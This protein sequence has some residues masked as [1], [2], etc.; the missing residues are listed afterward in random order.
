MYS[1]DRKSYVN[2][3]NVSEHPED[4]DSWETSTRCFSVKFNSDGTN[5]IASTGGSNFNKA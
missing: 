1:I 3:F 2:N 4:E 5:F